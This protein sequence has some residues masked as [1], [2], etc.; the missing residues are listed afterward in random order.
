MNAYTN[1][2]LENNKYLNHLKQYLS[3]ILKCNV[4]I[5]NSEKIIITLE[6]EKDIYNKEREQ[7]LINEVLEDK[8]LF[9]STLESTVDTVNKARAYL[10][11]E[12][13]KK[14]QNENKVKRKI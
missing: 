13:L 11:K 12:V 1:E 4:E 2:T 6:Y 7:L 14:E 5:K 8:G 3:I 9:I 10:L